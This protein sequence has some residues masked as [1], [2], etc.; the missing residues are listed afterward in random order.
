MQSNHERRAALHECAIRAV[1]RHR[2]H[3]IF[4]F[5][6]EVFPVDDTLL[7][8]TVQDTPPTRFRHPTFILEITFRVAHTGLSGFDTDNRGMAVLCRARDIVGGEA[9]TAGSWTSATRCS[10]SRSCFPVKNV[11]LPHD[12]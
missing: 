8:R 3:D 5:F 1:F 9:V 6:A 11:N 2:C 10:F 12:A 7:T 4:G